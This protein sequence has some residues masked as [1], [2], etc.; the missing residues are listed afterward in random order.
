MEFLI[1]LGGSI[2]GQVFWDGVGELP[3][4]PSGSRMVTVG[5]ACDLGL[6]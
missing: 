4:L 5:Q 6:V 2:L 3:D 1:V